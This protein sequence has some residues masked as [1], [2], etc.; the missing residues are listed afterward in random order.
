MVGYSLSDAQQKITSPAISVSKHM[1]YRKLTQPVPGGGAIQTKLKLVEGWW[2]TWEATTLQTNW[3]PPNWRSGITPAAQKTSKTHEETWGLAVKVHLMFFF[4]FFLNCFLSA[5]NLKAAK[6]AA[7]FYGW[8]ISC[9]I[10][11]SWFPFVFP[12]VLKLSL[13]THEN[14]KRNLQSHKCHVCFYVGKIDIASIS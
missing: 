4:F 11:T 1:T 3:V 14:R 9:F 6:I 7:V 5:C 12:A 2:L 10:G 8:I 13:S